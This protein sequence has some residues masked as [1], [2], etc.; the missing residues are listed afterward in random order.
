VGDFCQARKLTSMRPDGNSGGPGTG[1]VFAI[2]RVTNVGSSPA[3]TIMID[4]WQAY[5]YGRLM[6]ECNGKIKAK[7]AQQATPS[8]QR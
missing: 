3:I 6:L 7:C 1:D 2:I 4:P 8:S 5:H